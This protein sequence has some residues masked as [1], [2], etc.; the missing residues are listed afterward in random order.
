MPEPGKLVSRNGVR[1]NR[2]ETTNTNAD[3]IFAV[4]GYNESFSGEAGLEDRSR[5]Q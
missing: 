4:F 2:F 5:R 1:E 3:V